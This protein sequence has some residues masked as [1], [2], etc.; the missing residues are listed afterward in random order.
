SAN[1][2]TMFLRSLYPYVV[3]FV[4]VVPNADAVREEVEKGGVGAVLV[5]PVQGEGGV[6]VLGED[7]LKAL[8]AI[9]DKHDVLLF[10]DCVQCGSGRTGKFFAYEHFGVSP[11]ICSM[12]KGMGG[13]FPIGGCLITKNA[14]QFV[15]TRMHG[16]TYGGNPLATSIAYTV[17][18]EILRDGFLENVARNGKHLIDSLTALSKKFS[19][20]HEVRGLGLMVGVQLAESVDARAFAGKLLEN[21]LLV[22]TALGTSEVSALRFMPPL[23]VSD[24][25]IDEAVHIFESLLEKTS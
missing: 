2:P 5:E 23:I 15:T 10:F 22:S 12:A 1:E 18:N 4:S 19:I 25:E 9:C 11:D 13:G 3:W 17:V 7:F 16:S 14:G 20:I 6:H 21:G 8:R 24:S